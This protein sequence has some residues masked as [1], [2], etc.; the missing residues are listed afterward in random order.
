M[1]LSGSETSVP[2]L[3]LDPTRIF[4]E[5]CISED[6]LVQDL[7]FSFQ[8][9][10]GKVLKLDESS[11]GFQI[12][13]LAKISKCH[14]QAVLRLSELGYLH[15][16]IMKGLDRMSIQAYNSGRVTDSFIAALHRERSEYY[17]FIAVV[18]EEFNR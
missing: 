14:K 18:Q 13:P 2:G 1:P 16:V 15:N 12:D 3:T 6:V 8:G 7:I 5:D 10:E 17:R 9:I 11:L 4:N